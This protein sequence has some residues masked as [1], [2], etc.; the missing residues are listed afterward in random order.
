MEIKKII[1][2]RSDASSVL[3]TGPYLEQ[4]DEALTGLLKRLGHGRSLEV[5]IQVVRFFPEDYKA[6]LGEEG[7]YLPNFRGRGGLVNFLD[8][9]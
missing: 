3:S 1:I 8:P 7:D 2:T 9:K 5:E 6:T 4:L